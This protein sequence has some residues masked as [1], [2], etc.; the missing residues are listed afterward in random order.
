MLRFSI[1]FLLIAV[2]AGVL[3]LGVVEGTALVAAKLTFLVFIV[4]FLASLILG[5]RS[6]R[7]V[8]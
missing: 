6:P 2:V 5:S 4:L 8:V 3:G 7:D 1:L